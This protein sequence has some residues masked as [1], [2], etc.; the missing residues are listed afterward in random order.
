MFCLHICKFSTYVLCPERL[1][2]GIRSPR[3]ALGCWEVNG[4]LSSGRDIRALNYWTISLAPEYSLIFFNI[5]PLYVFCFT[6]YF[7][8]QSLA[9]KLSWYDILVVKI[10]IVSY[11][12]TWP[13]LPSLFP[14]LPWY[15]PPLSKVWGSRASGC[16]CWHP[17]YFPLDGTS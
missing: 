13:L 2:G 16:W 1:E 10:G 4:P 5:Y 11:W 17:P 6:K 8:P 15:L 12:L 9:C 14:P 7:C 3:P